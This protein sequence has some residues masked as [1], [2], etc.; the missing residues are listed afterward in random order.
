MPRVKKGQRKVPIL[1]KTTGLCPLG[2]I[3]LLSKRSLQGDDRPAC[4][5]RAQNY[6]TGRT[7]LE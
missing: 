1:K 5:I 6:C 4:L 7:R 2:V 3:T